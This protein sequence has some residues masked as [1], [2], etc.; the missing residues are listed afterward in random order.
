MSRTRVILLL[1]VAVLAAYIAASSL[2]VTDTK[3]VRRV[4]EKGRRA[5][6][7]RELGS[8]MSIIDPTY[9]D[10]FGFNYARLRSW[11]QVQFRTYDSVVCR[12]PLM[13]VNVDRQEAVC[14]L[15]F[16]FAGFRSGGGT[17]P[18]GE[19]LDDFPVYEDRLVVHLN[20]FPEGWLITGAE[21]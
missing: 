4:M 16:W 12:I 9:E 19:G 20:K 7:R 10:D 2:I 14:S 1:A 5:I 8:L 11:F 6:V 18:D 3:R 17:V 15:A 13:S 21:P